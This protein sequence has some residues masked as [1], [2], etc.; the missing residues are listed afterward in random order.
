MCAHPTQPPARVNFLHNH[1][2][3]ITGKRRSVRASHSTWTTRPHR[4]AQH[5]N[6]LV[7]LDITQPAT[8]N[9]L[10]QT[11]TNIV[12]VVG[13]VQRDEREHRNRHRGHILWL[14]GLSGAGKSTLATQ[15]ERD[16]FDRG[17]Q[18]MVLD[19]DNCR[20]RLN[21]D[22]SFSREDRCENV[23]RVGE[24]ARLFME[25]GFITIAALISPYDG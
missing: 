2:I 18:V 19:G 6:Q 1:P 3:Q 11:N 22:L 24:V 20:H 5:R 21:R 23:R 17:F 15:L 10:L 13:R 7:A 12:P 14:T 4:R 8:T 16:L 25:T 9:R